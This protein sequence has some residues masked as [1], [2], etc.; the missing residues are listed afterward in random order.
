MN[1][2]AVRTCPRCGTAVPDAE[3]RPTGAPHVVLCPVCGSE[4]P[5]S[6]EQGAAGGRT[7]LADRSKPDE[8]GG[9]P[10]GQ[11]MM[12][13]HCRGEIPLRGASHVERTGALPA[14]MA[15]TVTCPHCSSVVDV[16]PT[17]I[18]HPET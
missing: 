6:S 11:V 15:D 7:A 2:R 5:F 9:L 13:P 17:A 3:D 4:V 8:A 12:C 10:G 16:D 14:D 1:D 18:H